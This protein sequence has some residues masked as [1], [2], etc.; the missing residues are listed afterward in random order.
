MI[1][2]IITKSVPAIF[3]KRDISNSWWHA[4]MACAVVIQFCQPQASSC[5][6]LR[7]NPGANWQRSLRD[8]RSRNS[9]TPCGYYSDCNHRNSLLTRRRLTASDVIERFM[10]NAD[11]VSVP[12]LHVSA[13]KTAIF[14]HN[15]NFEWRIFAGR[16]YLGLFVRGQRRPYKYIGD[17]NW[18]IF[19][20]A[21]W[22][23]ETEKSMN[24]TQ[25]SLCIEHYTTSLR[26]H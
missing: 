14:C 24:K 12:V 21:W 8:Q 2:S 18:C 16:T 4:Q 17:L 6:K 26:F 23:S 15:V 22:T 9:A 7:A 19:C 11:Y 25:L 13:I 5:I 3:A 1:N 20:T 10:L